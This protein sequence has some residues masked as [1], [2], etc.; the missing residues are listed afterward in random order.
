[1]L[2]NSRFRNL[3]DKEVVDRLRDLSQVE[4]E[5]VES[6]ER[7]HRSRPAVLDK[8]RYMRSSEP[9][10]GYDALDPDAVAQALRGADAERVEGGARLRAQAREEKSARV[11]ASTRR[12]P[13]QRRA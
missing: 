5:A 11:R 1:M 3:T 4:L 2:R 8:L 9:L 10:E 7:A 13:G 6:Y 12:S